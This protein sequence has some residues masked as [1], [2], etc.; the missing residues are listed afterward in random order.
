MKLTKKQRA[1]YDY[2]DLFIKEHSYSPSYRDIAAGLG[3]SSVSSVAEHIDNLVKLGALVKTPGEAHS[4]EVVDYRHEE[5][6]SLFLKT[7]DKIESEPKSESQSK[8]INILKQAARILDLEL[9]GG[10]L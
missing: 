8:R 7:I 10:N 4:L 5:T 2:I 3:L 1:V 6:V 9:D